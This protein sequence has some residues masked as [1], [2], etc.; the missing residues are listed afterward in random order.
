MATKTKL[1]PRKMCFPDEMQSMWQLLQSRQISR[2]NGG[3]GGRN[4][5]QI[6]NRDTDRD[7]MS[8]LW[9]RERDFLCNRYPQ[10]RNLR[11]VR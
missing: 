6:G 7:I 5:R 8:R 10:K 1:D 4:R 9:E 3:M 11:R 2:Q